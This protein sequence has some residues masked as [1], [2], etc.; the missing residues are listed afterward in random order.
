MIGRIGIADIRPLVSCGD[1]PTKAAVG[2]TF[3]VSATVFRDVPHA[4]NANVVL[5]GPRGEQGPWTPM[6][7]VN[8]GLDRWAANVT[9]TSEG[10]WTYQ[11][12][13]WADPVADWLHAAAIKVPAG[14]DTEL[15]LEEGA[16]LL[17]RVARQVPEGEGRGALLD[18]VTALRD[19]SRP[20]PARLAA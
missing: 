1:R 5:R 12:E 4:A 2:E 8:P 10:R 7:C 11:I 16:L 13:A 15:M 19:V 20:A 17:H 14:I 3:T 9:P 18:V 6:R